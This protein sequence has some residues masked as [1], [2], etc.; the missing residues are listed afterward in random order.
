MAGGKGSPEGLQVYYKLFRNNYLFYLFHANIDKI[1]I[2]GST[3][4]SS[5]G[6]FPLVDLL[7]PWDV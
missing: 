6:L 4:C 1:N 5:Q 2:L 3:K 7:T